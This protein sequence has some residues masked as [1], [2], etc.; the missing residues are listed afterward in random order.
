MVVIAGKGHEQGQEFEDGRKEPF[1][2]VEVAREALRRAGADVIDRTAAW[3]AEAAGGRAGRRRA[4]CAG[5]GARR[6]RH[7]RG[8]AGRPV[9][10]PAGRARR[11]RQVRAPR[12]SRPAPGAPWWRRRTPS[13]PRGHGGRGAGD[14]RR[15]PARRRCRPWR[16]PGGASSAAKVVGV[17]GS[18]GKTSTKDILAA[19]LEPQLAHAR[20]PREPE[21]RDRAAADDPR[22]A[23]RHRG[24][25]A[26][27]GHAR[28]GPDRRAGGDR[29]AR[30][31]RDRERRARA[32]GAAGH[33]RARGRGQGRADPRPARRAP[34]AWCPAGEPLLERPPARRPRHHHLRPGRRRDAAGLR[35]RPA[36][37]SRRASERDRAGAAL[38]RALQP[39]EH[40]R[41]RWPPRWRSGCEPGG[42]R[43]APFLLHA[44]RG[45]GAGRRGDRGQRLLQR[46]PDVDAGGPPAPRRDARGA[47]RRGARHDG[48]AGP[49]T[50]TRS[51]ARSATRRPRWASTCS[52]RWGGGAPATPR[53]STARRTPRPRPE[54]AGG[55]ARGDRPARRPRADQGLA[56]GRAGKGRWPRW[57]RSSSEGWPP[58]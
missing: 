7:A 31:R 8:E 35:R 32:P 33:G 10:G 30:R 17:T 44:G 11:R 57:G 41:R 19:L 34:H 3:V 6:D 51:T 4:R 2:D 29:R 43:G 27:D 45:R 39:A 13:A 28:R 36:P 46:Q 15:R 56:L 52:S 14:R 58:C 5:P 40:A 20:E 55:A 12:R 25:G 1:D 18:T 16:A 9:R 49:G 48:G 21:H 42:P 26:R 50:P 53:A 24:A 37:R 38:R 22:G 54:E 23:A 47:P